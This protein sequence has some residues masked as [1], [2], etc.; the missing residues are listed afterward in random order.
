MSFILLTVV[1]VAFFTTHR[2][3]TL[4]LTVV[5]P[6]LIGLFT[7]AALLPSLVHLRLPGFEAD[8]E[9]GA[10]TISSGPTGDVTFGPGRLTV[11]TGPTGH[12]PRRE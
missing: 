7:I 9:A 12:L 10:A 5:T 4:L 1:W 2:V 6:V 11:S 3:T 8:L